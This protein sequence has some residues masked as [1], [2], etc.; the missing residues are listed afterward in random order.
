MSGKK[1]SRAMWVRIMCIA[2]AFLMISS[3]IF[4]IVAML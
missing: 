4:A 2:L 1:N 3:M